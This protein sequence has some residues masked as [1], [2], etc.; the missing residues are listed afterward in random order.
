MSAPY[1]D[2]AVSPARAAQRPHGWLPEQASDNR[3]ALAAMTDGFLALLI[4]IALSQK[5]FHATDGVATFLATFIPCVLA[6]SFVNHV[7]GT[8][9]LRGSVAKLLFGMRV[10]RWKDGRRPRFWQTLGRWLFG[11]VVIVFQFVLEGASVGQACG[12]RTV[13]RRDERVAVPQ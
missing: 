3:L 6:A 5:V 7:F 13:R 2:P 11:F 8:L 12:L 1:T 4:G 9:L 10:L